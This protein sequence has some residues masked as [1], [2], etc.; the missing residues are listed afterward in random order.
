MKKKPYQIEIIQKKAPYHPDPTIIFNHLCESRS[1]TLLLETAEVNKKKDL[2]SI[3][4]IDSAIRISSKKNLVKLKP[5]SINGEEILLAL[6]K[7]IPKKIEIYEKNKNII[8][9][10]P[11]IEKN[12]DEDKKLFSLSVFD[13]FRFMIKIFENKEKKSKA[14]FF[15]GLFLMI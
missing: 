11:K 9:V 6:K 15:G 7:R 2:E 5:L 3:M 14:M 4:I 8:L 1:A 12:L 10:F 13:A